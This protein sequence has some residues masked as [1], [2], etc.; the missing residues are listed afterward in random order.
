MADFEF[1]RA[2]ALRPEVPQS[3]DTADPAAP[4]SRRPEWRKKRRPPVTAGVPADT[5]K[6]QS[7]VGNLRRSQ[8]P[9][10]SLIAQGATFG[11]LGTESTDRF[12]VTI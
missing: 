4:E 6:R 8:A 12:G 9:R 1:P 3:P 2:A 7:R 11:G 10:Y 5:C